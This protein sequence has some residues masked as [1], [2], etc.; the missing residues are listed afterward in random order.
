MHT[1]CIQSRNTKLRLYTSITLNCLSAANAD[2]SI[3]LLFYMD[4]T[5]AA[6]HYYGHKLYFALTFYKEL[7]RTYIA[8]PTCCFA[9][10]PKYDE[11]VKSNSNLSLSS[12]SW[13]NVTP[14]RYY[15]T[16]K[17]GWSFMAKAFSWWNYNKW[18]E[19]TMYF[20]RS[21]LQ[22]RQ[23]AAQNVQRLH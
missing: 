14:N 16:R 17:Y 20:S 19:S 4:Q 9:A 5:R 23:C 1:P 22:R 3:L 11:K 13:Y 6:F 7:L 18:H 15:Y 21:Y 10:P 2:D 8:H 12:P